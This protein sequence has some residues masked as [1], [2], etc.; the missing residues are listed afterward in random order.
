DVDTYDGIGM[1]RVRRFSSGAS[2]PP[3]EHTWTIHYSLPAG[4][5]YWQYWTYGGL[6]G[7]V[8]SFTVGAAQPTPAVPTTPAPAPPPPPAPP[9]APRPGRPPGPAPARPPPPAPPRGPAEGWAGPLDPPRP[10]H[11]ISPR[12]F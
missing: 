3:G 10:R 5:W 2:A 12:P 8:Q 11:A 4:T 9:P 1:L 6:L 7:P